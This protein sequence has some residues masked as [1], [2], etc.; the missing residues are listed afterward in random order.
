MLVVRDGTEGERA[1]MAI[2]RVVVTVRMKRRVMLRPSHE[3]D[4]VYILIL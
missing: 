1:S 2:E 4:E 3:R